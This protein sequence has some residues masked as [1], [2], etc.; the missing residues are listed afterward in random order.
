MTPMTPVQPARLAALLLAG[1]AAACSSAAALPNYHG[2]A[3]PLARSFQYCNTDLSHADRVEAL[4]GLLTLEEKVGPCGT[5][6][7]FAPRSGSGLGSRWGR[8]VARRPPRQ[9][10]L[11]AAPCFM[12]PR[13]HAHAI[14]TPC[15][16]PALEVKSKNARRHRG[17]VPSRGTLRTLSGV[18]LSTLRTITL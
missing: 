8:R 16:W 2:C 9:S 14:P 7:W 10:C 18:T 4:L 12:P 5:V 17:V 6:V 11:P 1:A 13:T 15:R 3:T